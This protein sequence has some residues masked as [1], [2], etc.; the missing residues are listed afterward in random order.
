MRVKSTIPIFCFFVLIINGLKAQ[1]N[2]CSLLGQTPATAFPIC[3][4]DTFTQS[5]VAICTNM[6]VTVKGCPSN[7]ADYAD[8]NPYWYRF[9][10]FQSGTL[11]FLITP[12]DLLD[13]YDWQLYDVTGISNLNTV[14]TNSNLFVVGNWS[15]SS[16]VT[17]ASAKGHN[18]VECASAP[19]DNVNTFSSTPT[20]VQGHTYLLLVSHFSD[21]QSGYQLSFGG[22]TAVIT[23]PTLP[24]LK[25]VKPSCDGSVVTLKLN[26]NVKCSSLAADGSDFSLLPAG[27]TVTAASAAN[28]NSSFDMDSV[29]LVLSSPL[30]PGNYELLIKKGKDFNTLLDD[31]DRDIP[32]GHQLSFTIAP[33]QPTL[34]DS[35]APLTCAPSTIELVFKKNIRCSSIAPNGSD[36]TIT[37]PAPVTVIAAAGACDANDLSSSITL[38]LASPVVKGGTYTVALAAGIDGNTI[39]DECGQVTP[40]LSSVNFTVKD[41]VSA[42]FSYQ[43]LLGCQADTITFTHDGSNGVNQWFWVFDNAGISKYPINKIVFKTFGEKQIVLKVSNGFCSDSITQTIVLDNALKAAFETGPVLCPEDAAVFQNNSSGKNITGYNW[44]FGDGSSSTLQSPPDKN[45]AVTG[46]EKNYTVQLVVQNDANCYDTA[47]HIIK[48]LRTCYIAVP[49]AFTPNND[50][51]N[52]YLYPLNA[53][54][55]DNLD[56][57]VY[58]RLGQL[59]FHSTA[60]T[61]KWDGRINGQPQSSGGY[62]WTLRYTVHDTGQKIFR[63]GTSLLIR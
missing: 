16:G 10:C 14:Y 22:G 6:I 50:G 25:S 36:F 18:T 40:V 4:T 35:I 62:V 17:G 5:T 49:N 13:D 29:T 37:G 23:D 59:V 32:E 20:L 41:T 33:P 9:T 53:F 61:Q 51:F 46:S 26:K 42:A 8:K 19:Q 11:S 39:I 2:S 47:T 63:K 56:F 55:A 30:P 7:T 27:A 52:D 48:V 1:T 3:A 31:C 15:G 54:K 24:D 45:Y 28:C 57:K 38:T 58:N 21:N 60:W 43:L 34:P 12:N 44:F